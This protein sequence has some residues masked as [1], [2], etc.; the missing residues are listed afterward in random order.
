MLNEADLVQRYPDL[1][2]GDV[3]PELLRLVGQLDEASAMYR[4]VEPPASLLAAID[5]LAS[6]RRDEMALRRPPRHPAQQPGQPLGNDGTARAD[7]SR[8]TGCH[9]YST[10]IRAGL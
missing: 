3:E 6:D 4:A 9:T 7:Y 8:V 2:G 10:S 5:Q 1:L